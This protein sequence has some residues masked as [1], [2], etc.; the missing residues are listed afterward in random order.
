MSKWAFDWIP[1]EQP[2]PRS[3]GL[4]SQH[5]ADRNAIQHSCPVL[6]LG[7]IFWECFLFPEGTVST[8]WKDQP[9][10]G[11]WTGLTGCETLGL[12]PKH[13]TILQFL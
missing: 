2:L 9:I 10:G 1:I 8:F 7:N 5:K 4:D 11:A 3:V 13:L 6:L 12:V